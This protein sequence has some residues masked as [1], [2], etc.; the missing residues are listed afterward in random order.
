MAYM[1][2]ASFR[3]VQAPKA[4]AVV[5]AAAGK[6]AAASKVDFTKEMLELMDAC[7]KKDDGGGDG[8]DWSVVARG[9]KKSK[10]KQKQKEKAAQDAKEAAVRAEQAA[11]TVRLQNL[12]LVR[13]Q[14]AAF[15]QQQALNQ[16]Q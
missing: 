5:G 16:Q 12:E 7:G 8:A 4:D 2:D 11:E 9:E 1:A 10:Q 3:E 15:Q 14:Q 6:S 13:Q